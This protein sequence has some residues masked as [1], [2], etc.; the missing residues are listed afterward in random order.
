MVISRCGLWVNS[1]LQ[2]MKPAFEIVME[3]KI[4]LSATQWK[5]EMLEEIIDSV[6]V[7]KHNL[8]F[9]NIKNSLL[10]HLSKIQDDDCNQ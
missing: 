2:M 1:T 8:E 4:E 9:M 3:D 10:L 7:H 5:I 6:A